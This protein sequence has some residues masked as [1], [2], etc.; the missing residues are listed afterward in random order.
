MHFVYQSLVSPV[1]D[2]NIFYPVNIL[3]LPKQEILVRKLARSSV[4]S[5]D[6]FS[7]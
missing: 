6:I 1:I 5:C 3:V 7:P 2:V 4:G